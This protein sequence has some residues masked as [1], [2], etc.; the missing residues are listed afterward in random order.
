[1]NEPIT[2]G[3]T[4]KSFEEPDS[5]PPSGRA[6]EQSINQQ[7]L[8]SETRFIFPVNRRTQEF[9][10]KFFPGISFKDWNSWHWQ[11]KNSARSYSELEHYLN[12]SGDEL[13]KNNRPKSLPVRIT[14]YYLSLMDG[15][16]ANHPLRRCM[17]PVEKELYISACEISDPLGEENQSPVP[18]LVHRYPDRA[19]FL[20]TGFCAA[21]CRYCT[22]THMVAE[23][24]KSPLSTHYWQEALE[25]IRNT[26]QIRDVIISGG[27]P[28]TLPDSLIDYLLNSL[29]TIPHI[30]MVRIG[31]KAPVVLPQR[32]T[33]SLVKI[34]KK[35]Q[36]LYIN[37]HFTHPEEL[38][39]ETKMACSRLAGAGIPLGS[40]TVLLKGI[41]D[42][43]ET[44]KTL[45]HELLKARVRPYYIYQ[46]DPI[47]GSSHFRTP[48]EKGLEIIQGL[49][50]HTS[51]LAVPHYVIDSPGGG[52]KIPLLPEY[53]QGK[54]NGNV[55]LKNF[56]GKIYTYPDYQ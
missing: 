26:K 45:M 25:Y 7:G 15:D 10:E 5:E 50:G 55:I 39:I 22:R 4:S 32:I 43:V 12:L 52:G 11:L 28:L 2:A 27:D 31:T 30:E 13:F 41:N 47:P 38:T 3:V 46:C 49:R 29:F 9:K 23:K 36:P 8:P 56:E 18:N 35:Y 42:D 16:D 14:P 6:A 53:Y 34:L 51:G 40:Q 37:I 44:M 24:A 17:V 33:P 19:L 21:Y 1:M 20:V 54:K 48:V